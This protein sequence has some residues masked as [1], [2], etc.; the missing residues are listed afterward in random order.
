METPDD[1]RQQH[2][3]GGNLALD[4]LNT[5]NGPAGGEP[6]ESVLHDYDDLLAWSYAVGELTEG[7]ADRLHRHARQHPAAATTTFER[8][9]ATRAY[10]YD[11]FHEIAT[12]GTPARRDV[13]RLEEDEAEALGH[14][15]LAA[16]DGGYAWSWAHAD[17]LDLG[18]P[19]WPVVHAATTLLTSGPLDRVKGCALCRFHF[20]DESKNRSRRW[21][22]MG[23]CGTR[24][25]AQRYVARRAAAR[26][27]AASA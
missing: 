27:S 7:E 17:G 8:A 2:V 23:D 16:V 19:M 1:I 24:T 18:R 3:V 15:A 22:S 10:L 6:E 4:F 13:A 14:G 5:E 25:K 26:S 21:C 11:L 9:M 20:L 12:G